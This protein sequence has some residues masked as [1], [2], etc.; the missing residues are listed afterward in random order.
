VLRITPRHD[1]PDAAELGA[2]G[3]TSRQAEVLALV[4]RGLTS[5]EVASELLLSPRTVEKHLESIYLRLGVRN[6]AEATGRA[7]TGSPAASR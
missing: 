4:A 5:A 6:R 1:P 2:L 7:L 3:L